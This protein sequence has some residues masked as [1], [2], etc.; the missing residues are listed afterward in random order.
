MLADHL[1]WR[2]EFGIQVPPL[3]L[4]L[5]AAIAVIPADLGRAESGAGADVM[6]SLRAFDF[7]GSVLLTVAVTCFV[8]GLVSRS[9][10]HLFI[11]MG[12][13]GFLIVHCRTSA[14]T[15]SHVSKTVFSVRP[16]IS[17]SN[18]VLQGLI[19][20]LSRHSVSPPPSFQCSS[21]S[22]LEPSSL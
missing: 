4:C 20:W 10:M 15:Y 6:G 9:S 22:N 18:I 8:L 17:K 5:A 21:M 2:W 1:G 11:N 3:L 16:C 7:A 14:A 19:R 12:N 13:F